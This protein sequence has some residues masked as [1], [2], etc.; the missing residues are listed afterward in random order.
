MEVRSLRA[1][2]CFEAFKTL[3]LNER[4]LLLREMMNYQEVAKWSAKQTKLNEICGRSVL[5]LSDNRYIIK[6]SCAGYELYIDD[7]LGV[8]NRSTLLATSDGNG[9]WTSHHDILR[10]AEEIYQNLKQKAPEFLN[11]HLK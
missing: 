11:R 7:E 10:E 2:A 9:Q 5:M 8:F 1:F 3:D 4:D 6:L